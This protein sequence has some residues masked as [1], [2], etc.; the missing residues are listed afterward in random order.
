[1][2]SGSQFRQGPPPAVGSAEYA[3]AYNEVA[4]LGRATGSSRTTDQTNIAL[5]WADGGGTVTPPGHW[6]RIAQGLGSASGQSL[7]QNARM[8]ALLNIAEADA[9]IAAWD[10]KYLYNFWRPVTA[11]QNGDVDGNALTTG[12]ASWSP[13][14][15][16][17][18]FPTFTSGHSTFSAAAGEVLAQ[19]FGTDN[20]SFTTSTDAAGIADRSF[21]SLSQ[22]VDE[23]GMSRIYG[24]IH[25]QF[26]NTVGKSMGRSIGGWAY[27]H[28]MTAVPEPSVMITLGLGSTILLFRRRRKG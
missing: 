19:F 25:F 2:T 13:L 26:D 5:F 27:N 3:N 7:I 18:P 12:D 28:Y 1:M 15:T 17:P 8:F 10:M 11:I 21:T 4:T 20:L 23:A 24:G 14:I 6:N 9:A 22:A 16:T